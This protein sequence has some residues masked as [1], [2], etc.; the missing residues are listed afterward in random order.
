MRSA[1]SSLPILE[2]IGSA[3]IFPEACTISILID[4]PLQFSITAPLPRAR[5][6]IR[7]TSSVQQA[8]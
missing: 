3:C 6:C 8:P 4:S 1:S 5:R 2:A 7:S